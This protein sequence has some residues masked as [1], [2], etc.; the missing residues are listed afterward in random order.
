MGAFATLSAYAHESGGDLHGQPSATDN[1]APEGFS[2]SSDKGP[3]DIKSDSLSLDYKGKT[4]LFSGHV[5]ALQ[6]G[7][8]L[9]SDLLQVSYGKDFSDIKRIVADHNVRITQGGRWAS[10]EHGVLDQTAGTLVLTGNP[11]IHDGLDQISGTRVIVYLDS[12]KTVIEGARAVIFP[13]KQ[14]TR[15]NNAVNQAAGVNDNA[16]GRKD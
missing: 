5:H 7:T 14:Q 11:V 9:M 13:R 1:H 8:E 4:V 2:F 15:D 16:A 12:Q 6:S 3:I 10:G